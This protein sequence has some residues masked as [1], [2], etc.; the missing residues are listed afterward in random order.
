M[1]FFNCAC[2]KKILQN[3]IVAGA[4]HCPADDNRR[5]PSERSATTCSTFIN[6]AGRRK[7]ASGSLT[8]EIS[9]GRGTTREEILRVFSKIHRHPRLISIRVRKTLVCK[10]KKASFDTSVRCSRD[11]L[12]R[13]SFS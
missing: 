12:P 10:K 9:S 5:L 7:S 13:V 11:S 2:C 8:A 4:L 6:R 3:L 1:F